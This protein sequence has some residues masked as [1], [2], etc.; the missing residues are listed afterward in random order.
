MSSFF[1]DAS[2]VMIPSGYK[3]G[4]V[5]SVKPIDGDGDLTFTRSNDTAT[6]VGP[7]GLIEKV[8][9]N[10]CLQSQTIDNAT[11]W[12]NTLDSG[13]TLTVTA[14][15]AAAPDGTTTAERIQIALNGSAFAQRNQSVTLAAGGEFTY[16]VYLKS[17]SGTPTIIFFYDNVNNKTATLTG[18]WVRYTWTFTSTGNVL[19]RFVLEAVTSSSADFLA[20][21][22]QLE[23]GVSTAYI[24]TTTTAVSVG[25]IADLPR[26]DYSGG[27]TCPKLLLEPQRTNI[28]AYSEQADNGYW[29]KYQSTITAND[30][31]SPDGYTNADKIVSISAPSNNV[32][33]RSFVSIADGPQTISLFA[34]AGTS[35]TGFL[36]IY[37]GTTTFSSDYNLSNG[38]TANT[39]AGATA[40]ITPY[41]N[42]WYRCTITATTLAG[43][44]YLDYGIK[45]TAIGQYA[46]IFGMQF[47]SLSSYATSYIPTI[48]AST[49]GGDSCLKTGISSL[50]GQTEGT[51]YAEWTANNVSPSGRVVVVGDGSFANRIAVLEDGGNIRVYVSTSSVAQADLTSLGSYTGTHK[52][53]VAYANNDLKVYIDGV[54]VATQATLSVP[55]CSVLYVGTFEDGT[56]TFPVGGLIA[57]TLLFPTRLTNAQLAELTA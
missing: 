24:P 33:Y 17:L 3:D 56:G 18:D 57:Q 22:C 55:A 5:Y 43:T 49:R 6:R 30:T 14:N 42:G 41:G 29:G 37:D 31:T 36:Q 44:H 40:T 46:Y 38:T 20:W 16:S 8:R 10:L 45:S 28:A 52:I 13:A 50:I 48:A 11:S 51:I 26:L 39:T 54:A 1:D 9:T 35:S 7:D 34:K 47:E 12:S 4:T 21:G 25:P 23:T 2:L 32:I 27:A 15:H 19:P 53:A